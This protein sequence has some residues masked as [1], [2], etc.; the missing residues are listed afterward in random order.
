M[1]SFICLRKEA[2]A[3][4]SPHSFRFSIASSSKL[5]LWSRGRSSAQLRTTSNTFSSSLPPAP[6]LS[7][8][9]R[10]IL[11]V[12][13][14][15]LPRLHDEGARLARQRPHGARQVCGRCFSRE[16]RVLFWCFQHYPAG[17]TGVE[18]HVTVGWCTTTRVVLAR[19]IVAPFEM[20]A[21]PPE[22]PTDAK[23]S[24]IGQPS[25]LPM[26]CTK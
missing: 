26:W 6:S 7:R 12:C 16:Q 20:Y 3:R 5:T 11:D 17:I 15:G 2:V 25:A 21:T 10:A 14:Q 18:R 9:V 24:Y 23:L 19:T 8:H 4:S 1:N 22:A 13:P